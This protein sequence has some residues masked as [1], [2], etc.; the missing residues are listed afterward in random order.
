MEA[1][2]AGCPE[3]ESELQPIKLIDCRDINEPSQELGYA[4]HDAQPSWFV[5]RYPE[6]GKVSGMMCPQCGR[7]ILRAVRHENPQR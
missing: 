3:C 5:G 2:K 1:T 4:A 6:A 7:I